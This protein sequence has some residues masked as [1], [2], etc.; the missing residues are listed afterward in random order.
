[1]TD[2]AHTVR[3]QEDQI[4]EMVL[5]AED[6]GCIGDNCLNW[7]RKQVSEAEQRGYQKR[8]TEEVS[9]LKDF[10]TGM[11]VSIDVSTGEHDAGNRLFGIVNEVQGTGGAKEDMTL[12][13]QEPKPNFEV[14]KPIGYLSETAMNEITG[15]G[16]EGVNLRANPGSAAFQKAWGKDIPVYTH[17]S[18]VPELEK[19][20]SELEAENEQLKQPQW[21]NYA[22]EGEYCGS[23]LNELREEMDLP[24]F[25]VAEAIGSRT[26]QTVW[27]FSDGKKCHSFNTEQEAVDA[28]IKCRSASAEGEVK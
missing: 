25:E 20:I 21:F 8:A 1:M 24:S 17:P 6:A 4:N 22:E 14:Q 12:L 16:Y 23:T 26:V 2:K 5:V 15:N 13:V 10:V 9:A 18:R 28:A 27:F 19:R 3:T 7:A 11:S